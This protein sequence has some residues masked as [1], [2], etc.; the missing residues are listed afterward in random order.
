MK[1]VGMRRFVDMVG[2]VHTTRGEEID[3][4]RSHTT[5][6]GIRFMRA[7][8]QNE[9]TPTLFLIIFRSDG[10]VNTE[11]LRGTREP[12]DVDCMSCVVG[13]SRPGWS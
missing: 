4:E 12:L 2:V 6:C 10:P 5:A 11:W 7:N 8:L 3:T 9:S 13:L 1:I